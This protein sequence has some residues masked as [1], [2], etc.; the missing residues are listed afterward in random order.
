MLES[1]KKEHG[2]A[3]AQTYK[4]LWNLLTGDLQGQWDCI[5]HEMHDRNAWAGLNG[6]K[7]EGK[8]SHTWASFKDCLKLHK[9][10]VFSADAAKRLKFF[11]QQ[12]VQKP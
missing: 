10:M 4:F 2:S 9:L 12:G 11:I 7:H 1:A 6:E 3:M 5:C 8:C